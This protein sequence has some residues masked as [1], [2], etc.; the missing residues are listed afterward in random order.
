MSQAKDR[1]E[2]YRAEVWRR[3][4][5]AFGLHTDLA[6]LVEADLLVPRLHDSHVH[7]VLDMLTIQGLKAHAA[8][9]LLCQHGLMEEAAT[10]CRRLLELCVQ[11]RYIGL[12]DEDKVRRRRAGQYAA[13]LWRQLPRRVKLKLPAELRAPWTSLGR[14]YGRFVRKNRW[15]PSFHDMFRE[16]GRLDLYRSDYSLLSSIAH[17]TADQQVFQFSGETIRIHDDGFTSVLLVYASRY[18]LALVDAWFYVY[19]RPVSD[20]LSLVGDR[21]E[22][23]TDDT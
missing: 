8:V 20:D 4:V 14:G 3:H 7:L 11:A 6:G 2:A 10:A 23:W 19:E 22:A 1:L 5:E 13:Y 21:L 15:G 16:I 17:G 12:D 9:S 18:Y